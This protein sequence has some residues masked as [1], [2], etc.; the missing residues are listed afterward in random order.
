MATPE[1]LQQVIVSERR[2]NR[3]DS[4]ARTGI[5]QR[6]SVT[7]LAWASLDL[8]TVFVAAIMASRLRLDAASGYPAFSL[9][10]HILHST[11]RQMAP[12]PRLVRHQPGLL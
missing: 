10:P 1:Y 2:Q 11:P 6:P 3:R 4:S 12:V 5:F 8:V 7:S 9:L